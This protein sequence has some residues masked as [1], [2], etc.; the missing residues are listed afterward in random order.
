M[1]GGGK[2]R[3]V[4]AHRFNVQRTIHAGANKPQVDRY[5]VNPR[6]DA[7]EDD[8][9]VVPDNPDE[10]RWVTHY[11]I[12]MMRLY[13]SIGRRRANFC[14]AVG[15]PDCSAIRARRWPHLL[16]AARHA[17]DHGH[18]L[19]LHEYMGYEADLGVGWKQVDGQRQP[20]RRWHGRRTAAGEPDESYPYGYV[21]LRYR[22]IYDTYLKPQG[23][24][25]VPLLITEC[26]CDSVE[27][28]TP[29]GGS[30]GTWTEQR[31]F[32]AERGLDPAA[33]YAGMLQWYDARLR[34]DHFVRGAMIFTVGSVGIWLEAGHC[35]DGRRRPCSAP[36]QRNTEP[37]G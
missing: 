25:D 26:G 20:L 14:F 12:E 31:A 37:G 13:E 1:N 10:A 11:C 33:T 35:R 5:L 27:S 24:H 7:W 18:D 23:L 9:E 36:H 30:V 22:L 29:A 6:I 19:A 8:N 4:A 2:P 15:T 16:P 21:A 34:E 28:V 32:W 3:D 17:R